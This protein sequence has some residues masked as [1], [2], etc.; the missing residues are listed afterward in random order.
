MPS[1]S[2]APHS[3]TSCII[4]SGGRDRSLFQPTSKTTWRRDYTAAGHGVKRKSDNGTGTPR[5]IGQTPPSGDSVLIE[6]AHF[7]NRGGWKLDTQFRNVLGFSYL[8]AHGMGDPVQNAITNLRFPKAGNYHVWVHTKDWR[9]GEWKS[10]GRFKLLVHKEG[11]DTEF[12]TQPDWGWQSGGTIDI[13]EDKLDNFLELQPDASPY[14]LDIDYLGRK[15]K[16]GSPF[17]GPF[18]PRK[19]VHNAQGAGRAGAEARRKVAR[20]EL[21]VPDP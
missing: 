10:P 7:V 4:D 2:F 14:R 12:G 20:S 3:G 18:E 6:A 1:R 11:L 16:P 5:A 19:G 15:R 9:P 17:P 8:L 21:P 13:A